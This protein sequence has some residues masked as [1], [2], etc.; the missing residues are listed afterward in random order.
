[1]AEKNYEHCLALN[2]R[3]YGCGQHDPSDW[4]CDPIRIWRDQ[5]RAMEFRAQFFVAEVQRT[6]DPLEKGTHD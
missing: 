4:R 1:M 2:G 3:C 6:A 5:C